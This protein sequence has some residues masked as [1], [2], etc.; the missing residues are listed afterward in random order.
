M[1]LT[2]DQKAEI[3]KIMAEMDCP[4]GF[5]CYASKFEKLAPVRVFRGADVIQCQ[6][7][8]MADC[9]YARLFGSGMVLCECPLRQYAALELGK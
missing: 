1:Q 3:E 9:K 8:E 5:T 6:H 7:P 2:N 4:K